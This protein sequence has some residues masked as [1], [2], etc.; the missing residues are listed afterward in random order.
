MVAHGHVQRVLGFV[1]VAKARF[2]ALPGL[3]QGLD[4][5]VEVGL[6]GG[7]RFVANPYALLEQG[8]QA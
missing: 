1:Q 5:A 4:G 3:G 8:A 2:D 6:A 7:G